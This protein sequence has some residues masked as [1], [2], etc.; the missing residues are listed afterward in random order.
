MEKINLYPL[1]SY[2]DKQNTST[3][4]GELKF[5]ER[6]SEMVYGLLLNP[7]NLG[8]E[9]SANKHNAPLSWNRMLFDDENFYN[10]LITYDDSNCCRLVNGKNLPKVTPEQLNQDFIDYFSGLLKLKGI[11]NIELDSD[12]TRINPGFDKSS[13]VTTAQIALKV[14]LPV[15]TEINTDQDKDADK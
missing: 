14:N 10:I 6:L 2:T 1:T 12:S 4:D 8:D 15:D 3:H 7:S 9:F 5:I 11:K 13:L